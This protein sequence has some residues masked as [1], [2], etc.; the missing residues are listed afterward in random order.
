MTSS[1]PSSLSVQL[2]PLLSAIL[3]GSATHREMNGFVG[4]CLSM[5]TAFVRSK[6]A[7]GHLQPSMLGLSTSDIALDCL[8]DLFRRDGNGR[9]LQ[10][11]A[12]FG[13]IRYWD[14]ADTELLSHLRRLVFSKVNQGLFRMHAENDPGFAKILRNIKLSIS[15]LHNFVEIERFGESC[16]APA[17]C[18]TGEDLPSGSP[19]W[20]EENLVRRIQG[21]EHI[22]E[23]LAELSLFLRT[24]HEHNR[25]I[26]LNL[27]VSVFRNVFARLRSHE[28][29]AD[30]AETGCMALDARMAIRE[31]CASIRKGSQTRYIDAKGIAPALY[32]S[33]FQVIE[34]GLT[35]RFVE[36]D[37]SS[38]SLFRALQEMVPD[39]TQERYHGEHRAVLEYLFRKTSDRVIT[40]LRPA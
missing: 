4:I 24:Q 38:F 37:A 22:P 3:D 36:H 5:A 7:R 28:A 20:L 12:Y 15:T 27:A 39:L 18:D 8:A 10:I 14:I 16:I 21:S 9:M 6:A 1:D 2:R 40:I 26:S 33:Y 30:P 17:L 32:D 19:E 34:R 11:D 31:A 23:M 35:M 13:G 29:E 25:I